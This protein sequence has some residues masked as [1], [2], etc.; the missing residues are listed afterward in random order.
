MYRMEGPPP[1]EFYKRRD[2]TPVETV[3]EDCR[4]AGRY[5]P[6]RNALVNDV[7]LNFAT[8]QKRVTPFPALKSRYTFLQC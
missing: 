2:S 4:T 5:I 6:N 7:L 8:P 3:K 1:S